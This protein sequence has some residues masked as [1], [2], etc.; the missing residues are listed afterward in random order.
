MKRLVLALALLLCAVAPGP[1]GAAT[2]LPWC[3]TDV[4][5]FDRGPDPTPAFGVHV[6]YAFPAGAPDR[7]AEWAPRLVGD[8]ATIDAWWRSQDPTRTPRFDLHTFGCDTAFGSLD[9]SRVPL[10][11]SVTDVRS[12]YARVRQLLATEHAF[13][14]AEKAYLVYFDGPTGQT[15][16]ERICGEA[17]EGRRGLSGMAIVYLD[18][19]GASDGDDVRVIVAAH[20]LMHTLGAVDGRSAPNGCASGHVCDGGTDLMTATLENGPLESRVLDVGRNDYYGHGGS[21]DD[22]Q[23]SRFLERLDSPDRT[24]P[25]VPT[26]PDIT[27]DRRGTVRLTWRGATDDVGPVSYRV[28]R[29]GV[30]VEEVTGVV[31]VFEAPLGSTSVY[32]VRSVDPVGRMSAAVS[33][34]FTAGLG[35]VDP[36]G[37]LIRDTVPPNPITAVVVR[38]LRNR[39]VVSW[40]AAK[41]GGG[42]MGYRV[43]VGAR[44]T[45]T[46]KPLV[47]LTRA[48]VSGNLRI[49]PVDQAGNAGPATMIPVRRLR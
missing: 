2:P 6:I 28:Y 36:D 30:F 40:K 23:D 31:A 33:L 34:R 44:L 7:F 1:A 46:V 48:Q 3:G 47:S 24:A 4:S 19:C 10:S 8:A 35:V 41:D 38:K 32:A 29:D 14:Q 12:A 37:R 27:S 49:T 39:V 18:S 5:A 17:D 11:A 25:G 26:L 13:R 22:V 43:R 45:S 9:L 20:E 42:I 15:G 21:W 16:R